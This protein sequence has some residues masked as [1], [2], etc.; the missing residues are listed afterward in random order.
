MKTE[1]IDNYIEAEWAK[2]EMETDP[3]ARRNILAS[4]NEAAKLK[5]QAEDAAPMPTDGSWFSQ[6]RTIK[7][8]WWQILCGIA[9]PI[10]TIGAA[11]LTCVGAKA[12]ADSAVRC[13][14]LEMEAKERM[15]KDIVR[16]SAYDTPDIG[17]IRALNELNK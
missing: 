9:T 5:A 14:E 16:G 13:K 4:A 1:N 3:Q 10:A 15:L 6:E 8:T 12:Q 7:F 2:A 17:S 11:I